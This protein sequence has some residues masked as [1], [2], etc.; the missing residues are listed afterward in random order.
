MPQGRQVAW[1][2]EH[3]P[4]V[5][6]TVVSTK[7]E[8]DTETAQP[9]AAGAAPFPM[10]RPEPGT[11]LVRSAVAGQKALLRVYGPVDVASTP[12]LAA[13]LEPYRRAG[14]ASTPPVGREDRSPGRSGWMLILDLRSVEYIETPG[15]RLLMSLGEELQASSGEVRLVVRH[16][17]RVERT[18]DLV[19][20][21]RQFRVFSTPRE[22]WQGPSEM[23]ADP[24]PSV[25]GELA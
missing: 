12:A 18:L 20:L 25:P 14:R 6:G 15:L 11:L 23:A 1:P 21:D 16:A 7:P 5:G 13:A 19:G 22:A 10:T 17:S 3:R 24:P 4:I 8:S 9:I 2:G